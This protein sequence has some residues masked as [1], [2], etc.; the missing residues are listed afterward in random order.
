[1]LVSVVVVVVVAAATVWVAATL[2]PPMTFESPLYVAVNR[3]VPAVVRMMLQERAG[4]VAMQVAGSTLSVIW[5]V[6]VAAP[7]PKPEM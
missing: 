6:P 5:T 2:A 7:P 4:R 3:W 1:M